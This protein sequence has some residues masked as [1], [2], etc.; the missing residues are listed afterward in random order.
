MK[1]DRPVVALINAD[2]IVESFPTWW[3]PSRAALDAIGPGWW[4]KVRALV[5]EDDEGGDLWDSSTIWVSVIARSEDQLDC[6]V[7][8]GGIDHPGFGDGDRVTT[9]TDRVF[10]LVEFGAEGEPLLNQSRARSLVGKTVLIGTTSTRQDGS[11]AEQRQVVG[12]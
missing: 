4:I 12:R 11:V 1:L 9:T 2:T 3:L 6:I 5:I 10:D 7:E 8:E